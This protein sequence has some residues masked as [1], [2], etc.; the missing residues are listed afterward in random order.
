VTVG[1]NGVSV[2]LDAD[3]EGAQGGSDA[4][5]GV[6]VTEGDGSSTSVG[7]TLPSLQP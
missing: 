7:L 4:G 3:E 2:E 1:Q 6:A 5:V